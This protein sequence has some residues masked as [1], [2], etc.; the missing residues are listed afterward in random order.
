MNTFDAEL[1]RVIRTYT[2]CRLNR[3]LKALNRDL[4]IARRELKSLQAH[5]A[6]ALPDNV[7]VRLFGGTVGMPRKQR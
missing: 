5:L 7:P 6:E 2:R 4:R 3:E 1:V